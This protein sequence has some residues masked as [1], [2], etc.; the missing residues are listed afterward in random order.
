MRHISEEAARKP[1]P[2]LPRLCW[3]FDHAL[4]R[5]AYRWLGKPDPEAPRRYRR[6]LQDMTQANVD[7]AELVAA[8]PNIFD[9][10][11]WN[12]MGLAI[13]AVSDGSEEGFIVFDDFSAKSSKY[14]PHSV[15]ER[16]HNYHRSPPT[17]TGFGKLISLAQHAGWRPRA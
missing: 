6:P 17:R 13:F 16:W 14:D 9:W 1:G 3:E 10:D 7:L 12:R 11:G 4:G 15:E 5:A 2:D 8:V